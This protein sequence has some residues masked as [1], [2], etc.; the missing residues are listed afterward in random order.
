MGP[1]RPPQPRPAT[2]GGWGASCL[3]LGHE[4]LPVGRAAR[5]IIK[6]ARH[7]ACRGRLPG[8]GR[9]R[10]PRA[11]L[12]LWSPGGAGRAPPPAG[13]GRPGDA[14]SRHVQRTQA[15]SSRARGVPPRPCPRPPARRAVRRR[16]AP[17]FYERRAA[18]AVRR[19]CPMTGHGR[20]RVGGAAIPRSPGVT[21][22]ACRRHGR[23]ERLRR[24]APRRRGLVLLHSAAVPCADVW[25][26]ASTS[27]E[28]PARNEGGDPA[29]RG[30]R[31][32]SAPWPDRAEQLG[33]I[34]HAGDRGDQLDAHPSLRAGGEEIEEPR[35][36]TP[37]QGT[38][39]GR[40]IPDPPAARRLRRV[41]DSEEMQAP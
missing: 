39:A 31:P 32:P 23:A 14:A 2:G 30:S 41:C 13:L 25:R 1:P 34:D 12:R 35:R 38:A 10:K 7:A 19:S 28:P 33:T 26:P 8:R 4:C 37:A 11:G 24:Q 22:P 17:S 20:E 36:P 3:K 29:V 27:T 40:K 21:A 18:G 15:D 5:G 9:S 6:A 16:V